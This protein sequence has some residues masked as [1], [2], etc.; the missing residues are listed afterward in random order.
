MQWR[1]QSVD[2]SSCIGELLMT[3]SNFANYVLNFAQPK[4]K[5]TKDEFSTSN[6]SESNK[7]NIVHLIRKDSEIDKVASGKRSL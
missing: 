2:R 1:S 6:E 3:F 5:D 7:G 4:N